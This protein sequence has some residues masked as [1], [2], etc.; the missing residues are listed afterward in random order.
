VDRGTG[1]RTDR[2]TDSSS[3]YRMQLKALIIVCDALLAQARAPT[4]AGVFGSQLSVSPS[5]ALS[6]ASLP[7]QSVGVWDGLFLKKQFQTA[8]Q[9]CPSAPK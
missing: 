9:V 3:T 6:Y 2:W 4:V 5:Y 8:L 7:W 1:R